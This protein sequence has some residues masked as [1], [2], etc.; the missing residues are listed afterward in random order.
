M[1]VAVK[2]NVS[3]EKLNS[4]VSFLKEQDINGKIQESLGTA[5]EPQTEQ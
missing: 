4:L 5:K 2:Q 3:E 1:V